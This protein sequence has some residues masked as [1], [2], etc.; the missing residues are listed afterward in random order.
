M[1]ILGIITEYNPFHNGHAYHIAKA[2]EQTKADFVV[3]VMSGNFMQRG[4]PAIINKYARAKMA[5]SCGVDL[6]LEL[7]TYF[8]TGS[9][10]YFARGAISI[11][12]QLGVVTD[13]VFGSEI[14]NID[15]LFSIATVLNEEPPRYKEL[16]QVHTKNGDSFP[17]ARTKAL[18]TLFPFIPI[19]TLSSPNN[20]L[21]VEYCKA[22]LHRKSKIIP[23][24]I[25]RQGGMYHD[26][27]LD[28]L[29]YLSSASSIRTQLSQYDSLDFL[30]KHVPLPVFD[31]LQREY[32]KSF[33]IYNND[34]S[35]LL[36]YKLWLSHTKDFTDFVDI[37]PDLS[38]KI[39]KTLN[40]FVS[41]DDFCQ[42]LKS[43]DITHSRISRMLI[44][45]LLEI[46]KKNMD[47]F[48][49]SDYAGYARILGLNPNANTLL[50]NIKEKSSIPL[51]SKLSNASMHLSPTNQN[52]LHADILASHIY[53]SV[54]MQKFGTPFQNEYSKQIMIKPQNNWLCE[55]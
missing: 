3:A 14:D 52:L 16:L 32:L 53:D 28:E 40:N 45:I 13:L 35:C 50:S 39:K 31:I 51:L 54:V 44:H 10:E 23:S 15:T 46:T 2:K 36:Q 38:D 25:L 29:S 6:V 11:L 41:F 34:F 9:A 30:K 4:T 27:S 20:I 21:G 17:T 8:A 5:L 22:L 48:T 49:N 47:T 43:K 1:R 19:E 26:T 42:L 33:P 24:C 55:N 18:S 7:P 12:D 37:T